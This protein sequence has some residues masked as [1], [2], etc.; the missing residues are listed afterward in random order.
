MARHGSQHTGNSHFHLKV[1]YLYNEKHSS[2]DWLGKVSESLVISAMVD[3]S[4][5]SPRKDSSALTVK[6]SFSMCHSLAHTTCC[7]VFHPLMSILQPLEVHWTVQG[8]DHYG[9]Y[10]RTHTQDTDDHN[11]S[12]LL[13][14]LIM[15]WCYHIYCNREWFS[16]R[17]LLSI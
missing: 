1:R 2:N 5:S 10:Y 4:S 9:L 6:P 15:F 14:D 7:G 11:S 13:T 12:I 3:I 16:T 17:K 8:F